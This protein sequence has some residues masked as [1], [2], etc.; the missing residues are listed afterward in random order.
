MIKKLAL[1]LIL[2]AIAGCSVPESLK[3]P[4]NETSAIIGV[5]LKVK[6]LNAFPKNQTSVYFV[7]LEE[8]DEGILGKKIIPANYMREYLT[9]TNAF[10]VNAEPG[11]YA[12][13]C[14]T[15]LE[16]QGDAMVETKNLSNIGFLT[17]FDENAIRQSL[18]EVKSGGVAF[19]GSIEINSQL[20]DFDWNIEKNG[21][22]AQKHYYT[23]LKQYMDGTYY[24]G[25]L[26]KADRSDKETRAFLTKTAEYFKKTDWKET[27]DK[28]VAG[29]DNP[30]QEQEKET[31]EETR[32]KTEAEK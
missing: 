20:K 1:T 12:V 15:K 27:I 13:V 18:V 11:K 32:K 14:S 6:I 21:D 28:A 17:F 16:K 8:N 9:A 24:C 22:I 29:L 5:S 2:A 31:K 26:I 19:L 23:L 25:T 4:K 3:T 10:L 7:K 30:R